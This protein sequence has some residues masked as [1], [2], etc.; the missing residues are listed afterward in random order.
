MFYELEIKTH[1]RVPP[2]SFNEDVKEASEEL[3]QWV[4]EG[5]IKSEVTVDEGFDQ[6]PNAFRKLF[7]GDNFGKQVIKVADL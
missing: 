3:A 5:K 6:I 7:T 2:V 1:V 4:Q